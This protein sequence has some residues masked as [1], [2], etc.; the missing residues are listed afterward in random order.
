[1]THPQP[2]TYPTGPV[3]QAPAESRTRRVG[4]LLA[5]LGGAD[6]AILAMGRDNGRNK[7]IQMGLVLLS[8]S[9]LALLSMSFALSVGLHLFWLVG[10]LGGVVWAAIVL[11]LDRM[12]ILNMDLRGGF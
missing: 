9:G 5:R 2:T 4:G 11:N 7:F 1:M 10:L 6:P 3:P 12:L 8:T